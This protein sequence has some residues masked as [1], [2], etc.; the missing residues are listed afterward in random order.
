MGNAL[1]CRS[2]SRWPGALGWTTNRL[3]IFAITVELSMLLVFLEF[4]PLAKI[5]GQAAPNKS[6][7]IAALFAAPAVLLA[8]T[9]YKKWREKG[10][11]TF[12]ESSNVC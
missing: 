11:S 4:R 1:A 8:D 3:L 12:V 6:G 7:F 10:R 9:L 5:L 2:E